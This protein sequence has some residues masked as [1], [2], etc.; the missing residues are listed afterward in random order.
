MAVIDCAEDRNAEVCREYEVFLYPSVRFFWTN[1]QV[2]RDFKL[3]KNSGETP[4]NNSHLL[5]L[6][7][8]GD[9]DSTDSLKKGL[10]HTL[11][12][13]WPKGAPDHFPSLLPIDVGSKNELIDK[14]HF[15]EGI[16]LILV[17]DDSQSLIAPQ[18]ILDFSAFHNKLTIVWITH[19][20]TDLKH[21]KLLKELLPQVRS[22][23]L[24]ILA[25]IEPVTH[26]INVLCW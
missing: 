3:P 22:P 4:K 12:D 19:V 21:Q 20:S 5:G 2:I 16:P 9:L 7:Y 15:R 1:N 23:N 6:Q 14:I 10:I 24:P 11:L 25:E 13:F 26:T 8:D 17:V 18:I